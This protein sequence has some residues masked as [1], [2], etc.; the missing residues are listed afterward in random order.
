MN[1]IGLDP[2]LTGTGIVCLNE[3]GEILG[4]ELIKTT[5]KDL[6]EDRLKY[7][8]MTF[9]TLV[10]QYLRD[11]LGIVYIEGLA[12]NAKGDSIMQ[13]AGLHYLLRIYLLEESLVHKYDIIPPNTLKKFITGK[14]NAKK[15]LMLL[16]VYKRWGV[17]FNDN[18]MADA[19]SLAKKAF[20]DYNNDR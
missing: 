4:Q 20:D 1:F 6:I 7:I 13:L 10:K 18:N 9:Q 3:D 12:L 11:D 2:S 16:K 5:V 19:Y 15:E 14:G 17:E 8:N